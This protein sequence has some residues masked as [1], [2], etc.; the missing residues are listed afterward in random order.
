MS[1]DMV[2]DFIRTSKDYYEVGG[3]RLYPSEKIALVE[4]NEFYVVLQAHTAEAWVKLLEIVKRD[5][6]YM[7]RVVDCLETA[8]ETLL[9]GTISVMRLKK[10]DVESS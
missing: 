7:Q 4:M 5:P 3:V 9:P 1:Y 2:L 10:E 6:S 8:K